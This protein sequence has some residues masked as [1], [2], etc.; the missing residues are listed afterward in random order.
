MRD[1]RGGLGGG[2]RRGLGV[3]IDL[4]DWCP[5]RGSQSRARE[6]KAVHL[7]ARHSPSVTLDVEMRKT[8]FH[9]QRYLINDCE[10]LFSTSANME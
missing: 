1:A 3:T 9:C 8:S 10:S 2:L 4:H 7:F 6:A 5:S